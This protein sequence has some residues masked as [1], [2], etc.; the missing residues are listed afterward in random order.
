M[1]LLSPIGYFEKGLTPTSFTTDLADEIDR[2]AQV[3]PSVIDEQETPLP[4]T[5]TT[6]TT[7]PTTSTTEIPFEKSYLPVPKTALPIPPI[8]AKVKRTSAPV[9]YTHLTLPTKA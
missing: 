1:Q 3:E 2:I 5:T 4:A 9:S 6:T 7:V 8:N